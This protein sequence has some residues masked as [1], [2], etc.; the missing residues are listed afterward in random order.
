MNTKN[1]TYGAEHELGDWDTRKPIGDFGR[2]PKEVNIVNSNG[3]AA[4]PR[5]IS[6]KFGGEALTP[7][8]DSPESQGEQLERFLKIQP[9]TTVNYRGGPHIHIRVPGLRD[10]LPLLKKLARFV[11][12]NV[13]VYKLIDPIVCA[14]RRLD[15]GVEEYKTRRR[16]WNWIRLS[17]HTVI[18]T[19]RVD[20]QMK[21]KTLDEFLAAEVPKSKTGQ[22]LWHAQP[23]AAV[24]IRQLIQTDTI[25]FRHWGPTLD[26]QEVINACNWCRDY[27]LCAFDGGSAIDLYNSKYSK[28]KFPNL[29]SKYPYYHDM[30]MRWRATTISLNPRQV[31]EAN[32]K[33]I[34][35]G[36]FGA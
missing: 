3:I 17:Q 9:K 19:Y 15:E 7:P 31:V 18:P 1:W 26:P 8:T 22:V 16:I 13:E 14:P 5:L 28:T 12:E 25:E 23:R 33:A 6:Y 34:L 35:D 30:E 10:N 2:D 29:G 4:D 20:N 24:N 21:A 36:S 27:L 32:I 11:S